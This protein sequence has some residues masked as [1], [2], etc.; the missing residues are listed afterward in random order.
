MV[1][2]K[3]TKKKVVSYSEPPLYLIP[4]CST[5]LLLF[6]CNVNQ[7]LVDNFI[8]RIIHPQAIKII[9]WVELGKFSGMRKMKITQTK[10]IGYFNVG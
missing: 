1:H 6:S 7:N 5:F 4:L 2:K 10:Y 9:T 8:L 3:F